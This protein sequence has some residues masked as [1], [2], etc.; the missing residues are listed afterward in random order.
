MIGETVLLRITPTSPGE[1]TEGMKIV[2]EGTHYL[3]DGDRVMVSPVVGSQ[4]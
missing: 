3:N 1:L 4:Q 2:S